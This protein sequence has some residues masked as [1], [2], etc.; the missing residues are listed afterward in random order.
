MMPLRHRLHAQDADL[1]LHQLRQDQLLEAAEVGVH[2]VERHLHGVEV[3]AVLLRD[4]EHVQVDVR[5]LVAGEADVADL[6]GLLGLDERF[7][8][9]AS[10]KIRSGSSK[11]MISWCCTRSM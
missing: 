4:L 6:A 9:A 10:A 1:S 3:E 7:V 5:V 2:H 8:G 11:R